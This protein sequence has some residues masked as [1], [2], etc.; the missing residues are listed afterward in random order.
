MSI[1]S[2]KQ[3]W[4][5]FLFITALVIVGISLWYTNLLVEKIANEER[6]KVSLWADAITRKAD[7]VRFT[8]EFFDR[9]SEEERKKVELWALANKELSKDMQDYTFVFEVIRNNVTIPVIVTDE[10]G[11]V[12]LTKNLDTARVNDERYLRETILS[13][14]KQHEPIEIDIF[15]GKKHK[16][17]YMDSRIFSELKMVFDELIKTFISEVALNSASVPVIYTDSTQHSV[18]DY[19]QLDSILMKD[20]TYVLTQIESMRAQNAPIEINL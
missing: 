2:K 3:R 11:K 20:S 16:L 5:I 1:Y 6:N 19:G 13:M 15:K 12:S 17:Y 14:E 7:L 10:S 9:I 8:N 4:K 18:I